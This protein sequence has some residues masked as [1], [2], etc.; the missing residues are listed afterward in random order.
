M[1][2][3]HLCSHKCPNTHE[4]Q[5]NCIQIRLEL[6]LKTWFFQEIQSNWIYLLNIESNFIPKAI[7]F[8][9]QNVSAK[10]RSARGASHQPAFMGNCLTISHMFLPCLPSRWLSPCGSVDFY[11]RM[12]SMVLV[13]WRVGAIL[14]NGCGIQGQNYVVL[15]Q[16]FH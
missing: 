11:L 4:W 10:S 14:G 16:G 13:P 3:L 9:M 6:F 15:R 8:F 12:V 7:P 1:E 2:P 5:G